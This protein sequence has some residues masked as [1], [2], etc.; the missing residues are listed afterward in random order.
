MYHPLYTAGV[1]AIQSIFDADGTQRHPYGMNMDAFDPY[2]GGGR[3]VYCRATAAIRQF[4]LVAINAAFDSTN[5]V[6]KWQAT[7]LANTANLG[8]TVGV[9]MTPAATDDFIWVCVQGL[10][11]VNCSASVAADTAFGVV[12]TGQG[13]AIANGKQIVNARVIA[14]ATTTVAKAGSVGVN[15]SYTIE[16][17]DSNGWFIGAYLSGTGVGTNA[18]ISSIDPSGRLVT[19]DVANSAAIAGTVTATYNNSTIFY[20]VVQLNNPFAQGQVT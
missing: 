1:S 10:V 3:F 8:R 12:A 13:G 18:K 6:W 11:P 16:V 4:G 2:W 15:G 19:V 14:A 20:N 5:K 9:A 17:P 7:E